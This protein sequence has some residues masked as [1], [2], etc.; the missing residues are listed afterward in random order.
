MQNKEYSVKKSIVE[1]YTIIL[2][3][4]WD[5]AFIFLDNGEKSGTISILS[6]YGNYSNHFSSTGQPFKD[7]LMN[8]NFDYFMT[9]TTK[10]YM[11]FSIKKTIEEFKK[12]VL[13][14]RREKEITKEEAKICIEELNDIDDSCDEQYYLSDMIDGTIFEKIFIHESIHEYFQQEVD[15]QC[16]GFWEYIWPKFLEI[17]TKEKNSISPISM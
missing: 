12:M 15:I 11:K 14:T 10:D 9:K 4:G 2:N 7:F 5:H 8:L 17:L 1:Q 16:K 3:D 13:G 6:S